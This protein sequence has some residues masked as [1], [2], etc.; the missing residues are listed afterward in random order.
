MKNKNVKAMLHSGYCQL[1]SK[2]VDNYNKER[3]EWAFDRLRLMEMGMKRSKLR[4]AHFSKISLTANQL[5]GIV[6]PS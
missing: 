3:Y 6:H 2:H 1:S 4:H 5:R